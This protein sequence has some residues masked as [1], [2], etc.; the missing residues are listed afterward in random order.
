[1]SS[2]ARDGIFIK[3]IFNSPIKKYGMSPCLL[4]L[5][6][7]LPTVKLTDCLVNQLTYD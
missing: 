5:L 2:Q 6:L 7:L 1:M 4:K 3:L